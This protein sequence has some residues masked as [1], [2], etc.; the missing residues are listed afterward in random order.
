MADGMDRLTSA[1]AHSYTIERELGAG[2]MATVYLAHDIKHDRMVAVKVL[3]PEVAAV[4]GA[5]RFLK[6]IKV[7]A[8][9]HH[10]HI[11]PLHDSG[12][13]D[14]FLYYVMPLVEGESLRER[15]NRE[16]QL[17]LDEALHIT[18][19]VADALSYAHSHG[20]VH[21]DVKPENILLE[22]GHAAVADFG[23]ATAMS[24]VGAERLTEVGTTL[25]TLAYMSPEQA[26]GN[27]DLDGRS[28][29][30]SLGCVL[31]EMLAG[32]P[33]FSGPT[34]ESVIH[35]HLVVEPP[36]ITAIRP[37]VPAQLAGTIARALAKT[38]ADRFS[39]VA[40]FAEALKEPTT[41][42]FPETVTPAET[43]RRLLLGALL[44]AVSVL[45]V[46]T[47]WFI[48]RDGQGGIVLPTH[49]QLTFSGDII[50]VALSPDGQ[51]L[52]YVTGQ[53]GQAQELFVR[54]VEGGQPI[55]IHE[56]ESFFCCPQWSPDGSQLL[57]HD[58]PRGRG[59]GVIVPRLGGTQRRMFT[60][61]IA[62]W[63]P[64]GSTIL[65]WWPQAQTLWR[66]DA[67]TGDTL[68]SIPISGPHDWV[69]GVDWSPD[70]ERLAVITLLEGVHTLWTIALEAGVTHEV[71][72]DTLQIMSPQWEPDGSAV[73]FVRR[74]AEREDELWKIQITGSGEGRGPSERVLSSL[75]VAVR[76]SAIPAISITAEGDRL[77]YNR[78]QTRSNLWLFELDPSASDGVRR[79]T[80]LTTGTAMH[81]TPRISPD[82]NRVVYLESAASLEQREATQLTFRDTDVWS[83]AWSPDGAWVAFG[84]MRERQPDIWVVPSSGGTPRPFALEEFEG[85]NLLAWAPGERVAYQWPGDREYFLAS[86]DS[87][88]QTPLPTGGLR[89]WAYDPRPDPHGNRLA[90]YWNLGHSDST[91]LWLHAV[92][93][94]PILL[95]P[96][97]TPIGW[98]ADGA[99]VYAMPTRERRAG[100][101]EIRA[102]DV[103]TGQPRLVATLPVAVMP[104]NVS[105]THDGRTLVAAVE[106]RQTDAW[107][108]ENFD[109][110]AR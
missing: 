36:S 3:H 53:G 13:A 20:V 73:Y 29:L 37:A 42:I 26:A 46:T 103:A 86:F 5:E 68:S 99:T 41:G 56:S 92:E 21:R 52:A 83:P 7:T 28:D 10:P 51:Q 74:V 49:R 61:V 101:R 72:E 6:E 89:G 81:E 102:V 93:T 33:P 47:V 82:G 31:Y 88:I 27:Q 23:I 69:S 60:D 40:L 71:I 67:V 77:L 35:Q 84:A 14:G 106:E 58:G 4:L 108:V 19:E 90:V 80:E 32:Q 70:G 85:S 8:N 2:G 45:S 87:D 48:A 63:S 1:L 17:P 25:G 54:D 64:D 38:P 34:A 18:R 110:T 96:Q 78:L 98:S 62:I 75:T 76:S 105:L 65:S 94:A 30:Y 24:E 97:H 43:N 79:S 39:P 91:G 44:V 16:K 100:V 50:D 55:R 59:A 15:L 12:E 9:L 109:P 57:F 95:V 11:L 66:T 107:I 104:W 22:S